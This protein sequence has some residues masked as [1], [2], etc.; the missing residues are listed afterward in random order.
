MKGQTKWRNKRTGTLVRR[1]LDILE[2]YFLEFH[3]TCNRDVPTK[4]SNPKHNRLMAQKD[5][6]LRRS[7]EVLHNLKRSLYAIEDEVSK[8]GVLDITC[9]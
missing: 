1:T 3:F 2:S 7:S 6:D 5:V 4:I 8:E 9:K